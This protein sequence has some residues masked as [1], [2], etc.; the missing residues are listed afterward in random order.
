LNEFLPTSKKEMDALGW[1]QADVIIFTGDAYVDHPAFGAAVIGRV[2]QS[3][4]YKIAIVPQPNWRDDLRDFKKL[5]PPRL[6]FGVTAGAMDS[7][8]NRYTANKRLRSD[9][10][11]SADARPDLR[12]NRAATVYCQIIRRLFPD[13]PLVVGG[14]EAS[15]RRLTH[16]DFWDDELKPS[17]IYD[18]EADLM[19]YGAGEKAIKEIAHRLNAGENIAEMHDVP[20]TVFSV[21]RKSAT[22][23]LDSNSIYLH[24]FEQCKSSKLKFNFNFKITEIESNRI[25]SSRLLEDCG[26]RTTIVNPPFVATGEAELDA[27]YDLPYTRRPH[28]RY[29]G[30]H[31]PAYEMIKHS[32]NTHRGCFGGCSFCTISAHQ[33]KF[34]I[35]RSRESI[36]KEVNA[37]SNMPDFKGHISDLGGPSANMYRMKGRNPTACAAC[38]KASCIFPSICPNLNIDHSALTEIY[39][40]VRKHPKVKKLTIGSGI[41]YDLFLSEK[42]FKDESG[43]RYFKTVMKHHVSGRLKVAPEHVA[44]HVLNSV[45]KPSFSLFGKLKEY[46]DKINETNGLRLQLIPY[47]VSGLPGCRE[48]DMASLASE[49]KK[50]RFK[51]EQV[52]SFTPTPMT[53]ASVIFYTGIDPYTNENVYVARS[54]EERMKQQEYFFR[55]I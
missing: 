48:R 6:F 50:M 18:T 42:G 14:I 11:Y 21:P 13:T 10:A 54:K 3:D 9:D 5:G 12:P 17:V 49:L 41:R 38:K 20:Q 45:R 44:A 43:E 32:I 15:L 36:M 16:Y 1:T 24:S 46:F 51:P 29:A 55:N 26:E 28:P 47:F 7:M 27:A 19:V 53:L 52:Q 40:A 31:I 2:L 35:S 22:N 4:G 33:G 39:E 37:V 30:K 25:E 34:V 23:F 8:V